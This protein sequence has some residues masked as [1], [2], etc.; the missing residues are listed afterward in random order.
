MALK[1][2]TFLLKK[3][4]L[5]ATLFDEESGF[6][7]FRMLTDGV[8]IRILSNSCTFDAE[9]RGNDFSYSI[10]QPYPLEVLDDPGSGS[11]EWFQVAVERLTQHLPACLFVIHDE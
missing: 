4:H 9:N 5:Q 10:R 7:D 1:I 11:F 2:G 8:L 6:L 3:R